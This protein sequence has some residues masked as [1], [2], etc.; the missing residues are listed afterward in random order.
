MNPPRIIAESA[1]YI[2]TLQRPDGSIP[3]IDRGIWD[4]GNHGESVMG[5]A[6]AAPSQLRRLVIPVSGRE[7][8][9]SI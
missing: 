3:W 6:I 1:A 4:A 8:P 5:L 9:R 2:R 7:R